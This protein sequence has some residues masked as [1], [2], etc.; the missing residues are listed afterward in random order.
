[1]EK[2][3][4]RSRVARSTRM[5]TLVSSTLVFFVRRFVGRGML[6]AHTI[7]NTIHT[8]LNHPGPRLRIDCECFKVVEH[9]NKWWTKQ[10]PFLSVICTDRIACILAQVLLWPWYFRSECCGVYHDKQRSDGQVFVQDMWKNFWCETRSQ[11][12]RRSPPGS[13][14]QLYRLWKDF[15]DEK[16]SGYTL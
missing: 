7:P 16:C 2:C 4:K 15:Q 10:N 9:W 1:M 5:S 14:A 6:S 8:R 13:W 11:T 3:L 12:T